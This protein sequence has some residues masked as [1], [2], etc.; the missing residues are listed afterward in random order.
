MPREKEIGR[1]KEKIIS[2][3]TRLKEY[4][5]NNNLLSKVVESL[6]DEQK[7]LKERIKTQKLTLK[8]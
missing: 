4:N 7:N 8:N 3:D 1:L 5:A 2:M 6:E